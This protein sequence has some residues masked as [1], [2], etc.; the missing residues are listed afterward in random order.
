MTSGPQLSN[1][2]SGQRSDDEDLSDDGVLTDRGLAAVLDGEPADVDDPLVAF[3]SDA[4][5]LPDRFNPEPGG[6]L[7]EWF[8]S[9]PARV[10]PPGEPGSLIRPVS[11]PVF[12]SETVESPAPTPPDRGPILEGGPSGEAR[13]DHPDDG[14]STPA[15]PGPPPFPVVASA[16][17]TGTLR[18]ARTGTSAPAL[19]QPEVAE[20]PVTS[21]LERSEGEVAPSPPGS[22]ENRR[23]DDPDRAVV[24]GVWSPAPLPPPTSAAYRTSRPEAMAALL[25]P[26]GTKLLVGTTVILFLLTAAHTTGLITLPLPGGGDGGDQ[27]VAADD[28][29]AAAP[30]AITE[31]PAEATTSTSTPASSLTTASSAPVTAPSTAASSAAPAATPGRRVTSTA[32]PTSR[33]RST[34]TARPT[35]A[36]RA[37]S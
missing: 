19:D 4:R 28:L 15:S 6:S 14:S 12:A 11:R 34:S 9:R 22:D 32:A 33:R 17:E 5:R 23:A 18:A 1:L 16:V 36:P 10:T 29:Q 21:V 37:A 7:T 26:T 20:P 13:S 27:T 31:V 8:S 3:L 2:S 24:E 30:A 35:T 25:R